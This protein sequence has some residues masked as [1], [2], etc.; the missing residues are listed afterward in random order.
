M[1]FPLIRSNLIIIRAYYIKIMVQI[2]LQP[3]PASS[4]EPALHIGEISGRLGPPTEKNK[5]LL[6]L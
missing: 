1:L 6:L 3:K 5:E 4:A 2:S